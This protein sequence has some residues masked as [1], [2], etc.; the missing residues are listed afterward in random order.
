MSEFTKRADDKVNTFG[1]VLIGFVSTILVYVSIIAL[2]AYYSSTAGRL[3]NTRDNE[4]AA[5]ELRAARAAQLAT[6]QRTEYADAQKGSLKRLPID[7]AMALVV[8]DARRGESSLVPAVGAHDQPT[9]P[10][11]AGKPPEGAPGVLPDAAAAGAENAAGEAVIGD[12]DSA[13]EGGEGTELE[14]TPNSPDGS[15]RAAPGEEPAGAPGTGA[16]PPAAAE[17]TPAAAEAAPASAP[18]RRKPAKES[19]AP[20]RESPPAPTGAP[21]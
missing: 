8:E 16:T 7:R 9:I 13:V 12:A 10:A 5:G 1:I 14:P 2:Q 4:G 18:G 3:A 15:E 17:A 19:T 20:R 21:N 11:V 6:L